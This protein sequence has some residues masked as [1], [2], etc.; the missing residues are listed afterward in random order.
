MKLGIAV[1]IVR[2]VI[3]LDESKSFYEKMGYYKLNESSKPN[4]WALFT[5]GRINLLLDEGR[6]KYTGL[7]YFNPNFQESITK[8][9]DVGVQFF[10]KN[11]KSEFVPESAIFLDPDDFG[12]NILNADFDLKLKPDIFGNS[13]VK[14]GKFGELSNS[15]TD[16]E[17][18]I[19][20]WTKLG[21]KMSLKES[22][23]Y[24]WAI[25]NDGL[26]VLGFHQNDWGP[27]S[28]EPALT[29]FDPKMEEIIPKLQ[30]DGVMVKKVQDLTLESGNGAVTAPDGLKILLFKG[31]I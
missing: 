9:E 15:I 27:D 18:T 26:M 10:S 13:K 25:L 2:G 29:Y 14:F 3:D 23:P 5:D 21:Y 11:P 1:Q 16:L 12:V 4:N 8:M 7:I 6:M 20:F 22:K 24:P 31:A 30:E 28:D 19:K 17:P